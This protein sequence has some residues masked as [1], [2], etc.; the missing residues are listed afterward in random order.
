MITEDL[1]ILHNFCKGCGTCEGICPQ[2]AIVLQRKDNGRYF[3]HR[4]KDLCK[5][6]NLCYQVCPAW[7]FDAEGILY[8]SLKSA[9]AEQLIGPFINTYSGFAKEN[10]LRVSSAS[11]GIA[12]ALLIHQLESGQIDTA[13]VVTLDKKS[14]Y[15]EPEIMLA[16]TV[17]E[18]KGA[19]GSKDLTVALNTIIKQIITRKRKQTQ[20]NR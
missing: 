5:R 8:K 7:P 19:A 1:T 14:P 20:H 13:L 10:D 12:T 4:N 18:I 2:G 15:A 6:C 17:D 9:K 11:G 16:R 3:P